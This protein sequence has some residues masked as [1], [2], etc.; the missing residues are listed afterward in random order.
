MIFDCDGVLVD[1]ERLA[2]KID[3]ALL[4]EVGWPLSE[5]EVAA[6]FIGRS[7]EAMYAE[8]APRLGYNLPV[9]WRA[10]F[11]PRYRQIFEAESCPVDGVLDALDQIT[12]PCCVA[13]SSTLPRLQFKLGLTGLHERFEGRI[14]SASQVRNGKPAPDLFLYAADRMGTRPAQCVVVEDSPSGVQ[15]AREAGMRVLAFAGA[16]TPLESLAGPNTVVFSQ[17]QDLCTLLDEYD[18][19]EVLA[20]D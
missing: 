7:Q 4:H 11:E 15:A 14:S 16:L 5:A 12:L 18:S 8:I 19:F 6:R 13:S 1:S 3:R 9:G 10:R 2:V 20:V 17:M